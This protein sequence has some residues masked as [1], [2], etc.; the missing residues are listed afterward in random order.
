VRIRKIVAEIVK[1]TLIYPITRYRHKSKYIKL[2]ESKDFKKGRVFDCVM[3]SN[4]DELLEL[5]IKELA[6]YVDYFVIVEGKKTFRRDLRDL[7]FPK[8]HWNDES[9]LKKIRYIVVDD[10]PENL[11]A[12]EMEIYQRRQIMKGLFDLSHNDYVMIGDVDEL[13]NPEKIWNLG[14]FDQY[15]SY[16]YLNLIK[17]YKLPCTVG[18]LGIQLI[19]KPDPQYH[20]IKRFTYS[21]IRNGGWHF[22]YLSTVDKIKEKI[23]TF[24]HPEWDKPEYNN[25]DIINE[26]NKK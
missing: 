21:I 15:F 6:P 1:S 22:S 9:I 13:P 10:Y 17:K 2:I 3:Y 24:A 16:Y 18:L 8:I 12:M 19:N 20:R 4:E 5:R 26:K 14:A 25:L 7:N 23:S 11:D